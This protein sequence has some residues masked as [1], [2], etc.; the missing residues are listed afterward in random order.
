MQLR[1]SIIYEKPR[2]RTLGV[3]LGWPVLGHPRL[4]LLATT[5][6]LAPHLHAKL[7]IRLALLGGSAL[8]GNGLL[9]PPHEADHLTDRN[10]RRSRLE[11]AKRSD[12]SRKPLPQLPDGQLIDLVLTG[13]PDLVLEIESLVLNL[14]NGQEFLATSEK[15]IYLT[16]V[17]VDFGLSNKAND[18]SDFV[19]GLHDAHLGRAAREAA[20][21]VRITEVLAHSVDN[22]D[23]PQDP[24]GN[25]E[26]D[27]LQFSHES[28]EALVEV[29]E[30]LENC[31][32]RGH[33]PP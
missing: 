27:A 21:L 17:E 5:I 19:A 3:C 6:R 30:T 1:T 4:L 7:P 32:D 18:F 29:E 16:P 8:L 24:D 14:K 22:H 26:T 28:V 31:E 15:T 33:K 12:L 13:D 23:A 9:G 11:I 2:A 10:C 20:L 25:L